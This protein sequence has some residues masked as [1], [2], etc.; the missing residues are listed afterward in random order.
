M[1]TKLIFITFLLFATIII[2]LTTNTVAD[3]DYYEVGFKEKDEFIWICNTLNE[4]DME[5]IWGDDWNEITLF[6]NMKVGTRM[7]W[8]ITEINEDIRTY[9]NETG[10][11]MDALSVKY[12]MWTWTSDDDFGDAD[13]EGLEFWWYTDPEDYEKILRYAEGLY[14]DVVVV[15]WVPNTVTEYLGDLELYKWWGANEDTLTYEIFGQD[16]KNWY[17]SE[18]HKKKIVM[19]T[20][21]NEQG[22][23]SSFK[24]M[25][26]DDEVVCEFSIESETA[27][28]IPLI[29]IIVVIIAALAVVYIVMRKKGIK[30]IKRRKIEEVHEN[31]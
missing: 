17:N 5:D 8:E 30:L 4:D 24:I 2:G 19:E 3:D 26:E 7:K 12:D 16:R 18:I 6:E 23:I 22:I 29:I 31:E 1:R 20:I 9:S 15:P 13:E 28:L 27:F 25:N 10:Q 11:Y 14:F 21:Y